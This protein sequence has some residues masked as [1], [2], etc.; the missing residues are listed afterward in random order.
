MNVGLRSGVY[1]ITPEFSDLDH[2][3]AQLRP[4]LQLRPSCVQYRDKLGSASDKKKQALRILSECNA[5]QIPLIINDDW[6]LALEIG[7][8]GAHLGS[9]DG[10]LAQARAAAGE[11]FVLGAS[12]YN[13]LQLAQLACRQGASYVAFG[14]FF[15]SSTKPDACVAKPDLLTAAKSLNTPIAAIGGINA[16]NAAT[17]IAAGADLIAVINGVFAAPDPVAALRALNNCFTQESK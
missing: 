15:A 17:V 6:R 13:Q 5:A 3:C 10:S 8:H 7:A 12:C 14:A 1:L 4:L 2:F 16:D 11:H 9:G